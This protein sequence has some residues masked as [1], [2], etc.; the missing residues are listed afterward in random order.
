MTALQNLE[1]QF[2]E[3]EEALP[4]STYLQEH[5]STDLY[6]KALKVKSFKTYEW[7]RG[8]DT[9]FRVML[10]TVIMRPFEKLMYLFLNWQSK[11]VFLA[12]C[13]P[14]VQM[15][16]KQ[17]APHLD[18]IRELRELMLSGCCANHH[19]TLQQLVGCFLV[20][21]ILKHFTI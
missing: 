5:N 19:M 8:E 1:K 10:C 15:S 2:R 20:R 6:R 12:E 13:P 21:V 7:L 11:D 16:R 9:L 4:T 18:I 14:L 17:T 3:S